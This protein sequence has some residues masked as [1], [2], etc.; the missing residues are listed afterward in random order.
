MTDLVL[1]HSP[2]S[3]SGRVKALLDVMKVPYDVVLIDLK[4]GDNQK[5]EYLAI[6]PLGKVPALKHGDTVLIESGA[7]ML[8]LADRF[9]AAKM[10][11]PPDSPERGRY[12]EWFMFL[13][14]TV[15]PAAMTAF[16]NPGNADAQATLANLAGLIDRRIGEPF[17][18]GQ[19]MTAVDVLLQ[20]QLSFLV[21]VG[22]FD[23]LPRAK[24]FY[25][26]HK[27][28]IPTS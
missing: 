10:A 1:Y 18:L 27:N 12:Y 15:E 19:R 21:G 11:P 2:G 4:N 5:P 9:P 24:A 3:R 6:H 26:R 20:G 13:L 28:A 16:Q 22:L 23:R 25:E 8:Y 7:I 17:V 14:A